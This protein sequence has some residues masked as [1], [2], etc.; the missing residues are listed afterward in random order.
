MST[1]PNTNPIDTDETPLQRLAYTAAGA[2]ATTLVGSLLLHEGWAPKTIATAFTAAGAG[3]AW[4]AEA[5]SVRSIGAGAMSAAGSQLALL[6]LEQRARRSRPDAT[7]HSDTQTE[8]RLSNAAGVPA[9]ALQSAFQRAQAR[10][11]LE[12]RLREERTTP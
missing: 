7:D 3:L 4:K 9:G 10:L 12:S 1:K 6:A 8:R 11:A 5:P 2:G